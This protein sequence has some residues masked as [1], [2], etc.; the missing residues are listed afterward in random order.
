MI[1]YMTG[2]VTAI[3]DKGIIMQVGPIGIA[4]SVPTP[5]MFQS[6]SPQ[7]LYIYMHWNQEQG[8]SLYGFLHD[9]ERALFL[10]II[11]CPGIGPKIGLAVLASIGAAQFVSAIQQ[12]NPKLLSQVPGIGIKKAEQIIVQLKHKIDDMPLMIDVPV[13]KNKNDWHSVTQALESLNYSRAEISSAVSYVQQKSGTDQ[14]VSFDIL[15]RQAL[16]FLAK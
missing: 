8:P 3:R 13:A 14:T 6:G 15:L 10:C 7:N 5:V 12:E 9:Y 1:D 11:G 4:I 16:S 2:T